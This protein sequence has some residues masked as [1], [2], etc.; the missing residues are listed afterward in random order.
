MEM[1]TACHI[2]LGAKQTN[3]YGSVTDRRG[4]TQLA[5]RAAWEASNGPIPD[6]LTID[7]LCRNRACVNVDH[8]ELVTVAENSA[9]ARRLQAYCPRGHEYTDANTITN[10]RGWRYCRRCHNESRRVTA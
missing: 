9:R 10:S 4:G 5:H 1:G 2:W 8:M 6:G 3:G 7:H